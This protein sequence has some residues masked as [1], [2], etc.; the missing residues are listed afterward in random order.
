MITKGTVGA[1]SIGNNHIFYRYDSRLKGIF[2]LYI[3]FL[4]DNKDWYYMWQE[5]LKEHEDI[6]FSTEDPSYIGR[7]C[8]FHGCLNGK[9]VYKYAR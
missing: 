8:K 2:I 6:F 7:H 3:T 4:G 9:K 5:F 1:W